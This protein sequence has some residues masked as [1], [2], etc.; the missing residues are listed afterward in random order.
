MNHLTSFCLAL[1]IKRAAKHEIHIISDK[2]TGCSEGLIQLSV[3]ECIIS[4][5]IMLQGQVQVPVKQLLGNSQRLS[6]IQVSF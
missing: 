3:E 1:I 6:P 5:Y 2:T 4:F